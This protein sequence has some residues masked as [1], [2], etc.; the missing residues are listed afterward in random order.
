MIFRIKR[1]SINS[2]K[3]VKNAVEIKGPSGNRKQWLIEIQTLE[4]LLSL[5]QETGEDWIISSDN[6]GENCITIYDDY[7]E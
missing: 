4:E 3:P 5:I 6:S 2:E 7:L 1:V